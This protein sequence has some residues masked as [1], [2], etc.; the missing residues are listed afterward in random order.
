MELFP[1]I[2]P[3]LG[4]AIVVTWSVSI[5]E[6]PQALLALTVM[7]PPVEPATTLIELVVEAPVHPEGR[8]QV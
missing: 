1:D 4:G 5:N 7:T 8:V 3:G 6:V 2:I